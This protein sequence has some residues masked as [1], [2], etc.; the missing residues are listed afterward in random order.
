MDDVLVS[1]PYLRAFSIAAAWSWFG[2]EPTGS[3]RSWA[4]GGQGRVTFEQPQ[5]EGVTSKVWAGG[6]GFNVSDEGTVSDI[7]FAQLT[8]GG[9]EITGANHREHFAIGA[10]AS[11]SSREGATGNVRGIAFGTGR[12]RGTR[13]APRRPSGVLAPADIAVERHAAAPTDS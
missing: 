7:A 4:I 11:P 2:H 5:H 1:G 10:A 6:P 9:V 3:L 12:A 8:I 13:R